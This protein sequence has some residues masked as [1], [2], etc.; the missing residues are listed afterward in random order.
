MENKIQID[1]GEEP[2][3]YD[4][5]STA[6]ATLAEISDSDISGAEKTFG[7]LVGA[8]GARFVQAEW[9]QVEVPG[10]SGPRRMVRLI[11]T[12]PFSGTKEETFQPAELR[13]QNLMRTRL[14]QVWSEFLQELSHKQMDR[15]HEVVKTL[16][17]D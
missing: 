5:V 4:R 17:G 10:P 6:S 11:L 9:S 16:E 1:P 2:H 8:R 15:V 7:E 14:L 13:N 12:D 3:L